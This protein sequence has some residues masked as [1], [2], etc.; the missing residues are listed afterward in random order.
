MEIHEV[1]RGLRERFAQIRLSGAWTR[2]VTNAV[3]ETRRLRAD[4]SG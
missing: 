3:V 4:M 1:V 2:N